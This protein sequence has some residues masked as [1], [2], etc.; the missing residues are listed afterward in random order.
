MRTGLVVAVAVVAVVVMLLPLASLPELQ[1]DPLFDAYDPTYDIRVLSAPV[2][3]GTA[4]HAL[5]A[6]FRS[7]IGPLLSRALLNNNKLVKIR[8]LA[9]ALPSSVPRIFPME[10]LETEQEIGPG[11][12]ATSPTPIPGYMQVEDYSRAY[13]EGSL[14]PVEVV[15]GIYASVEGPLRP[16]G[17]IFSQ[18]NVSLA[19]SLAEQ[20]T[21]RWASGTSL[22][23]WDGV[24]IAVKDEVSVKGYRLLLGSSWPAAQM[25]AVATDSDE[26]VRRFEGLGAVVVGMTTP[27][28]FGMSPTGYNAHL[29]GPYNPYGGPGHLPGGSSSG[30]AVAVAAG[31]VPLALGFDG[32]GSIRVP[33]SLSGVLGLAPTFGRVP[34]TRPGRAETS[35]VTHVGPLTVSARDAALAYTVMAEPLAGHV[36]SRMYGG[37]LPPVH[38]S[39]FGDQDLRG[40]RV[41]VFSAYFDDAQ[42]EVVA[43]CR[44]A[45]AALEARGAVLVPV[46]VAHLHT[47]SV[48]HGVT[49]STEMALEQDAR[50]ARHPYE[51][52][53]A[54]MLALARAF[55]ALELRAA[56]KVKGWAM[57]YWRTQV[58]DRVD[59]FA[60]PTTPTTAP[61]MH[62]GAHASGESNTGRVL[63][64]MKFIFPCNLIGT[65]GISLPVGYDSQG[66]PIGLHLMG[67]HWEDHLLLR[68][69]RVLETADLERQIPPV[70]Y[71][72]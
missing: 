8:A 50:H 43:A 70:F 46:S 47:Q 20:S 64:L 55:S 71:A 68:L 58:F 19:L 61:K 52:S 53:S 11:V 25:P 37:P 63:Q 17:A 62:A 21:Q 26:L 51:R 29:Q 5:A 13:A 9:A 27:H 40:V 28:E 3:R 60:T 7:A 35:S 10:M 12:E 54:V 31:L 48:V 15:L 34:W 16:L 72:R 4:L 23:I 18:M 56:L 42:D 6:V 39:G 45:L 32:G 1:V 65:P 36:Y 57:D 44:A 38:T 33:A 66:L 14:T 41:G 69:A 67:R 49:I 30:S 59:V 22:G 2:A 24:P